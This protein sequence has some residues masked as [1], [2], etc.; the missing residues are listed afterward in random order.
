MCYL[1][2]AGERLGFSGSGESDHIK[3]FAVEVIGFHSRGAYRHP[4]NGDP[5]YIGALRQQ[6]FNFFYRYVPLNYVAIDD[7]CVA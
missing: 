7:G 6:A 2:V 3:R 5:D 1:R 4:G